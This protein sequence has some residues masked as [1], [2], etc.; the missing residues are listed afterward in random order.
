MC[1]TA[2]KMGA[3]RPEPIKHIISTRLYSNSFFSI[4][5]G[6]TN[7]PLAVLKVSFLRP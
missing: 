5:T 7:L 6:A 2:N 3:G 4:G 1:G